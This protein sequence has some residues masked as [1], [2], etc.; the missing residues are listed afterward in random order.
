MVG[1]GLKNVFFEVFM[2]SEG[3]IVDDFEFG[4]WIEVG[5]G[6]M[7]K[8]GFMG[9]WFYIICDCYVIWIMI[10]KFCFIVNLM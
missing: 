4:M 3:V 10:G 5:K 8:Y 1:V 7:L 2:I 6:I 9:D